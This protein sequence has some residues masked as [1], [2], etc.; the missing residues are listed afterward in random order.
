MAA[1]VSPW[2]KPGAWAL[3]AEEQDAELEQETQ[4]ARHVVEPP[5]AD[6]P[7]L[8]VAATA[9]PK[10]KNKGQKISLAEFTAFGAPKPVAQPEGLTHQDRMHLPTG[11][12][13]RTAEELDRNR[14]GGGFRSY[15][16]D[17]GNSRFSNGEESSDSKWG[18]GQR[19]E[20]GFGKESN[21]DGPSR[22]D[23]IDDWG[24]A[25]KSTVGN[26]FERRERGAGGSF[27]GGS[28]SKADESDS[29]VSNKSSVS[30]EGRR[31]GASG[32]GFDRE[33]KVG[34]TSDGG[35]D[36]DNW[37]RK[38][39][40]SNG[41]S[42]FDRERRVGFVSNGG[43]ADSE[44]WGKKKEESNGGL[45]ESTGRPRLNL[46]PRT[47]PVSNETSPGST[48]V[49]KPKGSN[50]FGEA[51]PRE[52][53]LAEKG[54]DW[55]KIDEE[56]ES[57]KIKEVAER[58]HSPSFGKR[59]FGIGNG[60]AGDRTERAWRKPDVADARPQSAEENESRSSSVEPENGHVDEH[61]DS[62]VDGHADE[63]ADEN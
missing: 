31:F 8:S 55:K 40:E 35:A 53:V 59:S 50:P 49:P 27:F 1:T 23:E 46:Q 2:A 43:G 14:L 4:N 10:K 9:K 63:H 41:G 15:G 58:D 13:E 38:K 42:G 20:G 19:R 26:G 28:Q 62:H 21:R 44:V 30:S 25:K 36:S 37:G 16:S 51:R 7:S 12:R 3:A 32:G 56:L 24:A 17:R 54:K 18:S 29:W 39:E 34:F 60:R 33:R 22:A 6:Y 57:V 11:P 61:V 47:L 52:E 5:S 45:S 48:A